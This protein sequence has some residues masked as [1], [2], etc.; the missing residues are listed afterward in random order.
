MASKETAFMDKMICYLKGSGFT[1]AKDGIRTMRNHVPSIYDMC[2]RHY[3]NEK[4]MRPQIEKDFY[5]LKKA[6]AR[7]EHYALR[8]SK[9]KPQRF[10]TINFLRGRAIKYCEEAKVNF[11]RMFR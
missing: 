7:A 3:G 11:D 4:E 2:L 6:L 10:R 8:A 1:L 5:Q 9:Y